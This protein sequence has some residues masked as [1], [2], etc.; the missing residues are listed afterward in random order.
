VSRSA[1]DPGYPVLD[2]DAWART[3]AGDDLWAQVRRTVRGK[4]VPERQIE[5]IASTILA[6]LDLR[7]SDTVLDLACGNGALSARLFA[8][9]GAYLGSD[10]SAYLIGIARSRFESPPRRR[11]AVLGAAEHVRSEPEPERFTKVLCYGSFAYFSQAD[12]ATVLR[13]LRH[14]FPAVRRVFI[15]NLPDRSRAAAFYADRTP[16]EQELADPNSQIGVWRSREDFA[17]LARSCGWHPEI[18]AMP[19]EF[20]AA[21]YRYDALLTRPGDG[22]G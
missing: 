10:K 18:T 7:P 17:E 21:E 2:Y 14:R 5:L 19:P 13:G 1:V 3:V 6:R 20:F 15:G 9:C 11:F 16:S 8:S 12:A 22:D 4:P